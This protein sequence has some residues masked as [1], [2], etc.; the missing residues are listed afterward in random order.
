VR[1]P[2][3]ELLDPFFLFHVSFPFIRNNYFAQQATAS[4]LSVSR[5]NFIVR[6]ANRLR[7]FITILFR[8]IEEDFTLEFIELAVT[9]HLDAVLKLFKAWISLLNAQLE[10]Y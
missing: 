6:L 7:L 1:L 4:G 10:V 8:L 2:S 9:N 3:G 5:F